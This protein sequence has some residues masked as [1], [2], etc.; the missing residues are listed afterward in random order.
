MYI[1]KV[2]EYNYM[3]TCLYVHL[4]NIHTYIN[5]SRAWFVLR[6]QG[7]Q[8][9]HMPLEFCQCNAVARGPQTLL[10]FTSSRFDI[11][12]LTI[13]AIQ[14]LIDYPIVMYGIAFL[15]LF[16]L[17]ASSLPV[18]L[19]KEIGPNQQVRLQSDFAKVFPLVLRFWYGLPVPQIGGKW[20]KWSCLKVKSKFR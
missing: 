16:K 5:I 2:N 8:H 12:L 14:L 20:R 11:M 17:P 15:C 7:V 10:S 13:Q 18:L 1:I 4:Q 19:R 9:Q 6:N 3:H